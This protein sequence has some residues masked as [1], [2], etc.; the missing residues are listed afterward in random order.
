VNVSFTPHYKTGIIARYQVGENVYEASTSTNPARPIQVATFCHGFV[1]P[2][3]LATF[4]TADEAQAEVERRAAAAMTPRALIEAM[5]K[6]TTDA[7]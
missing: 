5:L 6:G 7:E 3:S 4:S 1:D 2:R